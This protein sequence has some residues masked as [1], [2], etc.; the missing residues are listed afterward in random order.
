VRIPA[1]ADFG[2]AK[3]RVEKLEIS[4][5]SAN[6][7]TSSAIPC[8]VSLISQ[9]K[10]RRFTVKAMAKLGLGSF[11][12]TGYALNPVLAAAERVF[13]ELGYCEVSA[14]AIEVRVASADTKT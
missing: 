1:P 8:E 11:F 12:P 7:D 2:S 6:L 4:Q 13:L 14:D 5:F 9:A 10:S 3:I